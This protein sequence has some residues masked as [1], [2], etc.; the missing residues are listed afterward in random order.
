MIKELG[1]ILKWLG[2]IWLFWLAIAVSVAGL[3]VMFTGDEKYIRLSGLILQFAGMLATARGIQLTRI[4]F[5]QPGIFKTAKNWFSRFPLRRRS[6][7][8]VGFVGIAAASSSS[9]GHLTSAVNPN[10]TLDERVKILEANMES[11]TIRVSKDAENAEKLMRNLSVDLDEEKRLRISEHQQISERLKE[12]Q[13]GG[14]GTAL[15]GLIWLIV[16]SFLSTGAVE[17]AERF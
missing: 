7:T 14:L 16:G 5:G 10:A 11:L 17:I 13:T 8:G 12:A 2:E 1:S 3:A 4:F 15:M 9:R 6:S